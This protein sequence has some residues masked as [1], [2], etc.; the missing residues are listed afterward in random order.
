MYHFNLRYFNFSTCKTQIKKFTEFPL[1]CNESSCSG[2]GLC[3]GAG[4]IPTSQW[5]KGSVIAAAVAEVTVAAWT[6]SLAQEL[7]YAVGLAIK[8]FFFILLSLLDMHMGKCG[9]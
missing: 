3:R 6:Q 2:S 5:I 9:S 7:L 1:W 4:L 8:K